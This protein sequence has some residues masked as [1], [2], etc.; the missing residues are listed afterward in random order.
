MYFEAPV[1]V[2]DG[3]LDQPE[4]TCGP[5]TAQ[6]ALHRRAEELTHRELEVSWRPAD[7]PDYWTGAVTKAG[8]LPDAD[9]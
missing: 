3:H 4:P 2:A 8:P 9:H 6:S 5:G 7:L 1:G